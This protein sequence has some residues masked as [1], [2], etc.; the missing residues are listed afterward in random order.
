MCADAAID[1]SPQRVVGD[2]TGDRAVTV[3][4]SDD[5]VGALLP[6]ELADL[7]HDSAQDLIIHLR[8]ID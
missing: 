6:A 2:I 5:D 3:V 8:R 7:V 4:L 1:N